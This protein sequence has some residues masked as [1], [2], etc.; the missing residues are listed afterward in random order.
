M[1]KMKRGH[2]YFCCYKVR[3]INTSRKYV[4]FFPP[5]TDVL[6]KESNIQCESN[7]SQSIRSAISALES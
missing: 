7:V 1:P 4:L 5:E 6:E 3:H 2:I